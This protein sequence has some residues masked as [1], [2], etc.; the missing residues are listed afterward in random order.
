VTLVAGL[1]L[2]PEALKRLARTWKQRLGSGGT[3]KG[4]TLELQ[5]D[6]RE[7]VKGFL[8]EHP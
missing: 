2:E 8:A 1:G 5:G 3:V 7:E 6:V 4:D